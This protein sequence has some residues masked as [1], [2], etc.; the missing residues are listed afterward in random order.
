MAHKSPYSA[1]KG[2]QRLK[3]AIREMRREDGKPWN[4]ADFQRAMNEYDFNGSTTA[5]WLR[6]ICS[7][8]FDAMAVIARVLKRDVN[9]VRNWWL[10]SEREWG[11]SAR[12]SGSEI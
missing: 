5:N 2:S 11:A 1:S 4:F 10:R 9:D 6:A 7:P 8:D 3:V 12:R